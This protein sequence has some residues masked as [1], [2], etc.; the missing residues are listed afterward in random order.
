MIIDNPIKVKINP[1]YNNKVGP[2]SC[3]LKDYK[4]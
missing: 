1:D 2:P 3:G 4:N